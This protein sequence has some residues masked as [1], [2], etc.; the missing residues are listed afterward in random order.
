MA[1]SSTDLH[2]VHMTQAFGQKTSVKAVLASYWVGLTGKIF[3]SV[4]SVPEWPFGG[5]ASRSIIRWR[6][7]SIEIERDFIAASKEAG[8]SMSRYFYD[9]NYDVN[10]EDLSLW[11][12]S[13]DCEK[14]KT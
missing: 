9:V 12:Y 3:P 4:T 7:A 11:C 13:L 5:S 14:G 2:V 10:L 1:I 8:D 6:S